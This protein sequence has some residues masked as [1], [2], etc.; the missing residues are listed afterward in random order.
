MSRSPIRDRTT[1]LEKRVSPE[2]DRK[3]NRSQTKIVQIIGIRCFE[4]FHSK[5]PT[6]NFLKTYLEAKGGLKI[7]KICDRLT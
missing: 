6:Q 2:L 1:N 5:I 3:A 7:K 4:N